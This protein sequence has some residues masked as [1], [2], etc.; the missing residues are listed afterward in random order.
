MKNMTSVCWPLL[1]EMSMCS[2]PPPAPQHE[3][4]RDRTRESGESCHQ[5]Y[6]IDFQQVPWILR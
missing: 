5:T 6:D 1:R 2:S 4:E 3:K